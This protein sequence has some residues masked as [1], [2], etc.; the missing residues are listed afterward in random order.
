M[1]PFALTTCKVIAVL[2]PIVTI[3]PFALAEEPAGRIGEDYY[4]TDISAA[5]LEAN[6]NPRK[7][8]YDNQFWYN[9]S[10]SE[11]FELP[12]MGSED[13][14]KER[15]EGALGATAAGERNE[16]NPELPGEEQA[17]LEQTRIKQNENEN[18]N[19]QP[20][21]QAPVINIE[22]INL[23]P[24]ITHQHLIGTTTATGINSQGTVTSTARP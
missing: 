7:L 2:A 3:L 12:D 1:K 15:L 17:Q 24:V 20:Q 6:Q 4:G 21:G 23:V 10:T 13:M 19:Q 16:A 5:I 8:N 14:E 11:S 22:N 9:R 18:N